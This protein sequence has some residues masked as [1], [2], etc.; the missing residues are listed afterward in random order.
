MHCSPSSRP[1]RVRVCTVHPQ[2][3]LNACECAQL[4]LKSVNMRTSNTRL[5]LRAKAPSNTAFC[6]PPIT[7]LPS[8]IP[9]RAVATLLTFA[10]VERSPCFPC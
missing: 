8:A 1:K 10:P 4:T 6:A 5:A 2:V 7:P 3:A 9:C